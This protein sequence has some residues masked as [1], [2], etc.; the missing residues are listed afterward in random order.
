VG[1]GQ[2]WRRTRP[3][4]GRADAER[5]RRSAA[6]RR[7]RL[8]AW[9]SIGTTGGA[10]EEVG[11]AAMVGNRTPKLGWGCNLLEKSLRGASNAT[12]VFF[13]CSV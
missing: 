10:R 7:S 12:Q 4:S 5:W 11:E 2:T 13:S 3:W 8:P 1:V 6:T 9:S